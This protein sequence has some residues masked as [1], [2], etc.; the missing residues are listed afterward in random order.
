MQTRK[1]RVDHRVCIFFSVIKF[2]VLSKLDFVNPFDI[3]TGV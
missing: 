3:F 1:N 2:E